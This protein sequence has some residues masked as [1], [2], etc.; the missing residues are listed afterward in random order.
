MLRW[1]APASLAV[2]GIIHDLS[3]PP[4]QSSHFAYQILAA[5]TLLMAALQLPYA[6]SSKET[7]SWPQYLTSLYYAVTEYFMP[8]SLR[9][10]P[11]P[12]DDT[13][14]LGQTITQFTADNPSTRYLF[15]SRKFP[16]TPFIRFRVFFDAP[17]L[18]VTSL[19]A[20]KEVLLKECYAFKKPGW[21]FRGVA[22]ISGVGLLFSEFDA[23]KAQRKL[24]QPCFSPP[25]LK[26]LLPV[27]REKAAEL[28]DYADKLLGKD[29]K[30]VLEM[31]SLHTR[32]TLVVIGLTA[33]GMDL[34]S[35]EH[36][37][38][39]QEIYDQVFS[40]PGIGQ[41]ITFINSWVPLRWMPIKANRDFISAMDELKDMLRQAIRRRKA[42]VANHK[43]GVLMTKDLI[44]YMLEQDGADVAFTEDVILGHML[45]IV[46]AGH[47]TTAST[48]TW[49]AYELACR[50]DIQGELRREIRMVLDSETGT[51]YA[52]IDRIPKLDNFVK[53]VLRMYPSVPAHPREAARDVVISGVVVPKGT[54]V[55]ICP[56]V[57]NQLPEVWGDDGREFRPSRWEGMD[58]NSQLALMTF[59]QGPRQCIGKN[60]AILEMKAIL[61]EMIS[62]F[63]FESPEGA[64]TYDN[65]SMFLRPRNGL[66]VVLRRLS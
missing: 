57:L 58:A 25:N 23:H 9:N 12:D 22:E 60:F 62:R 24:L 51:S 11:A 41:L 35:L 28:G 63:Q 56:A 66:R 65:P 31:Y 4:D 34:G 7:G 64:P 1:V 45:N 5:Y 14:L 16:R 40:P 8:S 47:E 36:E 30:K 32:A 61:C 44:G 2:A 26:K 54:N 19:G 53:E 15:L 48:L 50:P 37:T 49:G 59:F 39:F 29:E 21:F 18:L 10:L 52:D 38:R 20:A 42:E 3:G 6:N 43:E 33:L 46:G 27:F 17:V 55:M 13:P